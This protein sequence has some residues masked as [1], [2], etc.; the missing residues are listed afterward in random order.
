[1]ASQPA[2]STI[3]VY[4]SVRAYRQMHRHDSVEAITKHLRPLVM[5][6]PGEEVLTGVLTR[7]TSLKDFSSYMGQASA[8]ATRGMPV[9]V[10]VK[11]TTSFADAQSGLTVA[12]ALKIAGDKFLTNDSAN[13]D[14][15][16][17]A[18]IR[19]I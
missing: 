10:G 16:L 7:N 1:M 13:V 14:D 2:N 3:K 17:H 15:D 5:S 12:P 19:A 11:S 8:G 9:V 18:T 6:V 4:R